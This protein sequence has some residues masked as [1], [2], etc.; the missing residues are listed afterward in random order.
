MPTGDAFHAVENDDRDA[1]EDRGEQQQVEQLSRARVRLEDD[2]V[3]PQTPAALRLAEALRIGG[4]TPVAVPDRDRERAG[5]KRRSKM[6]AAE[7]DK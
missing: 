4:G 5:V 3:Q 1:R 6:R 2:D 7:P